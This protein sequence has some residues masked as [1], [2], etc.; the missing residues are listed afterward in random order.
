[1]GLEKKK[2]LGQKKSASSTTSLFQMKQR[3]YAIVQQRGGNTAHK[4]V[5][6]TYATPENWSPLVSSMAM[7]AEPRSS[8]M[9]LWK[10][11][12]SGQHLG[13]FTSPPPG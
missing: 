11:R 2:T 6:P 10:R 4:L 12:T 8:E 5:D 9:E 13:Y 1:M 7:S 3:D